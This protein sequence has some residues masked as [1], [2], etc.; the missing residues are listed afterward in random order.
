MEPHEAGHTARLAAADPRRAGRT[1]LERVRDLLAG[2]FM[3]DPVFNWGFRAGAGLHGALQNYFEFALEQQCLQHDQIYIGGDFIAAAAWLPP[4]GISSLALPTW[5][6]V[7][8]FPRMLRITGW[9]RLLRA[10]ALGEALEKHH[11]P[12]PPH[13]YLFFLGVAPDLKGKGVGSA[14]LEATLKR[15][16]DDAMPAYLDNSNARNTRLYE[17]HGF[18]VVTEYRARADAPPVW[19]M[20][21]EAKKS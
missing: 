3:E 10:V 19:G 5:R 2:A 8:M 14:I 16:D 21:R 7:L 4:D 18:R 13:W 17:R 12:S 1:D 15:A 20:W 11:P 9:S 6:M